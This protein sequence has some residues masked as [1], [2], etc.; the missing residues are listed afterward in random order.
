[1]DG[2]WVV[3]GWD[4]VAQGRTVSG[5]DTV[6]TGS[7]VTDS[8]GAK[9]IPVGGIAWAGARSISKVEVSVDNGEWVAAQLR[10]PLSKKT[11]VLWRYDWPF[12]EGTHTF[13]VRAYDGTGQLQITDSAPEHPS[14]ATGIHMVSVT[15]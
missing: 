13:A 15:V 6:A 12:A 14:G 5:V 8:N 10:E 2:Y 4:K 3:R 7:V 1:M 9:M 11:W